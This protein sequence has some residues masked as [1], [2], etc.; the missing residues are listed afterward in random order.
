[1]KRGLLENVKTK[2][3][4]L[5]LKIRDNFMTSAVLPL[6]EISIFIKDLS[7]EQNKI[8][9]LQPTGLIEEKRA[10]EP[11]ASQNPDEFTK[12]DEAPITPPSSH[13]PL[14]RD[15]LKPEKL[16]PNQNHT[17]DPRQSK[18]EVLRQKWENAIGGMKEK[19]RYRIKKGDTLFSIRSKLEAVG[20]RLENR[21]VSSS[22]RQ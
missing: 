2:E 13:P 7:A 1:M 10:D 21:N 18:K 16:T 11:A 4:L 9:L 3:K 8:R 17:L 15:R 6:T 14:Y 12:A 5:K 20:C 22:T 19:D